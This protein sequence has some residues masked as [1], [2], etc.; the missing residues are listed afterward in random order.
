MTDRK[1]DDTSVS[2]NVAASHI[3]TLIA[4]PDN[5]EQSDN[6]SS[7]MPMTPSNKN[8]AHD[9]STSKHDVFY[10]TNKG[11]LELEHGKTNTFNERS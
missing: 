7:E 6:T 5:D 10:S 11:F 2:S 4:S 1:V 9:V 3:G 8:S